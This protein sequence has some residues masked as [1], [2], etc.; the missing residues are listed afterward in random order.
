MK[1]SCLAVQAVFIF[2]AVVLLTENNY[3]QKIDTSKD[4]V[5]TDIKIALPYLGSVKPRSTSEIES[6]N[7]LLGC[8]TLDRDFADYDQYKEYIAPLGIKRL[9]MQA[10]WAKTEKVKGQYDWAWL[11]HIVN[12]AT[13]RG[14]Q[15]WLQTSYGNTIYPGGGGANLG[16][17]MPVSKEALEAY[18][19]WVTALVTRYKDKVTEWE[20]WNEPNF[21]DNAVNTPE[22][23]ASCG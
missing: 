18:Y 4:R 12:D 7:W 16:A 3:A 19:K 10:G 22:M 2:L 11:D 17:G 15:P 20:V 21:A 13:S 14:L 6:S 5:K 8:E 9:R 23:T 1:N